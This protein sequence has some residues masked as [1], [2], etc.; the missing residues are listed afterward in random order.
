MACLQKGT[1]IPEMTSP[2][3][4]SAMTGITVTSSGLDQAEKVELRRQVE[5]MAGVYS[6]T[7]HEGELVPTVA[8]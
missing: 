2:L 4:T 7:F 3:Y 1:N 5:W 6:S 8:F